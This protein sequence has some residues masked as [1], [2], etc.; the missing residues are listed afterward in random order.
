[1]LK[2]SLFTR[3]LAAKRQQDV[4]WTYIKTTE[5]NDKNGQVKQPCCSQYKGKKKSFW[6]A[7]FSQLSFA[8]RIISNAYTI[9]DKSHKSS[10]NN[11]T[12]L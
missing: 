9:N 12:A 4:D 10:Y 5:D 8:S 7:L 3:A 2:C 1:M 6:A 11:V